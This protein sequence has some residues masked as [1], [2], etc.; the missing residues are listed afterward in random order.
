MPAP[1]AAESAAQP[2]VKRRKCLLGA[3]AV[4]H[5]ATV[6]LTQQPDEAPSKI[7]VMVKSEI[8][9]FDV[10]ALAFAAEVR[11]I[12]RDSTMG[13]STTSGLSATCCRPMR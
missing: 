4:K 6:D 8:H 3:V 12:T 1:A 5:V 11:C 2:P 13:D 9:Q 10:V 7:D